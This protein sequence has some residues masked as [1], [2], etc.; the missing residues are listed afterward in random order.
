MSGEL[1]SDEAVEQQSFHDLG[2]CDEVCRSCGTIP[3]ANPTRIQVAAIPTALK[4]KDLVGVAQ[5]GSGKTGAFVLPIIHW[6]LMQ[7]K[8]PFLSALILV[9][10]RELAQQVSDQCVLLGQSI[11]LKVATLVGGVD[12]VQQACE[13]AN[14]PHVVIGT[15]GRV[16]DHFT[17]TKGFHMRKLRWLV[18]DEAD[19]MLD[20]DYEAELDAILAHLPSERQTML[21]S[22]TLSTKIDRLQ[23]ASLKDPALIEVHRKNSTVDT[24]QQQFIFCPFD[25]ML[26]YLHLFLASETGGKHII[27]FCSAGHLVSRI[28]VALRT[29]GH[30]AL[31]LMGKMTQENREMA[32]RSFKEGLV[33][34]LIATDLAQRGLDIPHCD[35]VVNYGLPMAVKEYIHRVGRT[36]RAGQLGKAVNIISQYDLQLLQNVE[37]A[38]GVEMTE[39]P[40]SDADVE[41]V[42]HRVEEAELDARREVKEAEQDQRFSRDEAQA[43][44]VRNTKRT[45][46]VTNQYA[47]GGRGGGGRGGGHRGGGAA[48]SQRMGMDD[49]LHATG[50]LSMMKMRR[51]N[52]DKYAATKRDRRKGLHTKKRGGGN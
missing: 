47:S 39:I 31:P 6:L 20:M 17:N 16:K 48:V 46:L 15:P 33:R 2:L 1:L 21:F 49:A 36:A 51:E 45:R 5:T 12:M 24:L 34:I 50:N 8:A 19:K 28:T 52:E 29:L 22:A 41:A 23:K 43:A 7:P 13:L 30:R 18:M 26:C 9:P 25:K 4:G 10:T 11:G 3:W 35:V 38:T 32:L 44:G 42:L 14:K 40:F 37:T 27:V